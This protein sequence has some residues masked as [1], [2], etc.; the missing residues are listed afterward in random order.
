MRTFIGHTGRV[1]QALL[2]PDK[3]LV[4]SGSM[5]GS[6]RLWERRTGRTVAELVT[7]SGGEW[8]TLTRQGYFVASEKARGHVNV[9]AGGEVRTAHEL[10]RYF[11]PP[12]V[13]TLMSGYL[14]HVASETTVEETT[15]EENTATD[16]TPPEIRNLRVTAAGT[17]R[18]FARSQ[19]VVP[20]AATTQR[21]V[22]TGEVYDEYG[23]R[24]EVLDISG[25]QATVE[26]SRAPY[27]PAPPS[28]DI[29]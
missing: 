23:V 3:E 10:G 29:T 13:A 8:A 14:P 6:V 25:G 16:R 11:D 17:Q 22:L 21:V 27:D 19:P 18:S 2:S 24:V 7:V 4:I 5:D 20:V 1:S 15:A 28:A 26:V 9:R 12:A